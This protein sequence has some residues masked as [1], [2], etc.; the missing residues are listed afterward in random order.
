M[1]FTV[2]ECGAVDTFVGEKQRH[3]RH[4]FGG[5]AALLVADGFE[6]FTLEFR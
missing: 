5:L 2:F 3:G 1:D 4:G 6:F